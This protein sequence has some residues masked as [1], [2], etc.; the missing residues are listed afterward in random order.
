MRRLWLAAACTAALLLSG[1]VAVAQDGEGVKV[2]RASFVRRLVPVAQIEK[3]G[4][5]QYLTLKSQADAKRALFPPTHPQ[6]QRLK[7]IF[8]D[9]LPHVAKWNPRKR[10]CIK[11]KANCVT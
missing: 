2:G 1:L 5:Q 7:R 3:A 11:R 9:I 6:A 8:D 10:T 4:A